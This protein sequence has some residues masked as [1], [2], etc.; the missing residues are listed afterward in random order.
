[1]YSARTWLEFYRKLGFLLYSVAVSDKRIAQAEIDVL[2][3]ELKEKW[4]DLEGSADA[5]GSDA[6]YQVESVFDWLQE[7]G[8]SSSEAFGEFEAFV[9][10]H[11][12]FI[13]GA[14]KG[15]IM[16]TTDSIASAFSGRNKA[17]LTILHQ[18]HRLLTET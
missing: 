3:K 2:K 7:E 1:M 4:L 13:D 5:F 17:E 11:P 12:N 16:E 8:P 15:R 18:L 10:E 14:L 9:N 6:A